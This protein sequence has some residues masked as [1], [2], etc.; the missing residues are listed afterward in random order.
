MEETDPGYGLADSI[1]AYWSSTKKIKFFLITNKVMSR[2]VGGRDTE[3]YQGRPLSYDVWDVSR[4]YKLI[5]SGLEREKLTVDFAGLPNGPLRAL[6]A[7]SSASKDEA[8][9]AVVP[10]EDLAYIYDRWGTRLLEQNV[11]VFLQARSNVN[12]GIKNTLETEPELFFSFNNGIAA[13]AEEVETVETADGTVIT[14]LNNLQIV[15]G[16]QTTASIYAAFMNKVPLDKVFVQMKLSVVKPEVAIDLVP[17]ISQCANNQNRVSAADFFSN[18]PYHVRM[19]EFS[20]RIYAPSRE[21]CFIQTKWFY[22]RA[23]GQYRDAQV[24]LTPAKKR[25]FADEYP[26]NQTFTKTDLAKYLM[27]WTDK[28]Y[29]VNRGAQK[30]FAEFAKG[31][32]TEW[33]KGDKLFNECYFKRL[34]AKKIVFDA[35]QKV[36]PSRDWYETGG[37]RAQHVS[38][39]VGK[40][41][42]DVEKLGKVVDFSSI[43]DAQGI[44]DSFIDALGLAA[45]CVHEILMD[46]DQGYRN[47][48]EWAK[49]PACWNR[50]TKAKVEWNSDWLNELVSKSEERDAQRDAVKEQKVFNGIE[51]QEII[52]NAGAEFWLNVYN[53]MARQGEGLDEDR[54]IMNAAATMTSRKIPSEKQC[55]RI[56]ELMKKLR[57]IGCPYRLRTRTLQK[58]TSEE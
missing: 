53:W 18:H 8:Y 51:A 4:V 36:V 13:T 52:I 29:Y 31:I 27:C 24:Y 7:F 12:K 14:R 25:K 20:R 32:A 10:G 17:R 1:Q 15:N 44:S 5:S 16:G 48:S 46:P 43:W 3:E 38:F 19:E 22:E 9:L 39:V 41:A 42:Y 23:R 28:V 21:G 11:R 34:V 26:K 37:Y 45:D 50:I 58:R 33:E 55:L 40:I 6:R 47:I 57:S 30:N 2:K 35:A 54:G 56:L 49:Q